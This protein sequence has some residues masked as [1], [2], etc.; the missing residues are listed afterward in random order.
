MISLNFPVWIVKAMLRP[1]IEAYSITGF[2][3]AGQ[4]SVPSLVWLLTVTT[5]RYGSPPEILH[6]M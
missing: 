4:V 5:Q 3:R 6:S 1:K 2:N